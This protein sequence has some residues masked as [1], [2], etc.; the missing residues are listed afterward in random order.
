[1]L[2][3]PCPW[4]GERD[5][6]EFSYGGTARSLPPLDADPAE[7]ERVLYVHDN[8][9]GW[10][11]DLWFHGFGCQRWFALRRHTVTQEIG[12]PDAAADDG[13]P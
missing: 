11:D 13:A 4:C 3:I 1:M 2:L 9:K 5:E 10:H 6:S 7:W 12:E 8:P